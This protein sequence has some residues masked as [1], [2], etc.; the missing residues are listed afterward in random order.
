[1][2]FTTLQVP[3]THEGNR[4][5]CIIWCSGIYNL[6]C[7]ILMWDI[8]YSSFK[9]VEVKKCHGACGILK[10][11]VEITKDYVGLVLS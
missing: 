7:L 11:L 2:G 4:C 6:Q 10:F 9:L 8:P 3:N 5:S 1:M